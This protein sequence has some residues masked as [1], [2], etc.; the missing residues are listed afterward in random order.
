MAGI[1][2]KED[3]ALYGRSVNDWTTLRVKWVITSRTSSSYITK[4]GVK[5]FGKVKWLGKDLNT[6]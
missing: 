1:T 6:S 2:V 5:M 4:K 3:N